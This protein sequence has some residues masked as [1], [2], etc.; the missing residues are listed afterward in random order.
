MNKK[1]STL[2]EIEHDL[3]VLRL[4][5]DIV[6]E[7]LKLDLTTTK[8]HLNPKKIM[9]TTGFGLKQFAIDFALN[10]GLEWLSKLRHKR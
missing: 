4:Q 8:N 3:K 2:V 9:D 6:K 7:T 1:Y 5:R 10:K